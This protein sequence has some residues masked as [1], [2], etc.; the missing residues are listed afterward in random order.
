VVVY[1]GLPNAKRSVDGELEVVI[2]LRCQNLTGSVEVVLR[3]TGPNSGLIEEQRQVTGCTSSRTLISFLVPN[4]NL[5]KRSSVRAE[6]S[7]L[8]DSG[9]LLTRALAPLSGR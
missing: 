4:P 6:V 2:P 3:F 9:S 8:D 5:R 7:V 1:A